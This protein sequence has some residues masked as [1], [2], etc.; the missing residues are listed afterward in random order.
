MAYNGR[1]LTSMNILPIYSPTIPIDIRI[2]LP[3]NHIDNI[4]EGQ[5]LM[6]L[7]VK[8][9]IST[10]IPTNRSKIRNINPV[11][12]MNLI[13]LE[14]ND[15]IPSIEKLSIFTRGYF[16]LPVARALRL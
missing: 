2:R 7:P 16:V 9:A 6:A 10:H 3:K 4:M 13:G 1:L 8:Y 11:M 15:V 12:K 14:V 5:P